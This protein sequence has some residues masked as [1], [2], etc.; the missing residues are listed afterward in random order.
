M[1]T[2]V[3]SEYTNKHNKVA[4]Y[5]HWLILKHVGL[6]FTDKYCGHILERVINVN[7]TTAMWD[8]PVVTDQKLLAN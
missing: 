3:P 7:S 8:V 4:G 5:I 1:Y 6:R 2:L